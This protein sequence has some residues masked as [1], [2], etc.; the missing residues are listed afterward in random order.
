VIGA[1]ATESEIAAAVGRLRSVDH[2]TLAVVEPLARA[3]PRETF[4]HVLRTLD[5]RTRAGT[6]ANDV[7]LLV[8]LLR[9]AVNE[10]GRRQAAEAA[11]DVPAV[12]LG[13]VERTKRENP[14]G[15]LEAMR[16]VPGFDVDGFLAE[17]VADSAERER[18]R[19]L[20]A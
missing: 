4:L 6:V 19:R 12:E 5:H 8:R 9:V 13:L 10:H 15:Y 1:T 3:L 20:A 16:D 17:Y 7:G 14:A 18:L 11:S 2:G